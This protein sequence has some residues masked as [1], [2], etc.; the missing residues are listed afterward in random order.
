MTWLAI[1]LP[2]L[3]IG[4]GVVFVAFSGGPSAAREAYLTRGNTAFRIVVPVIY[5]LGG[6]VA[7]AVILANREAAAGA[8]PVLAGET[9]SKQVE[10]GKILFT[11]RCASCHNL[12]AANARGVQ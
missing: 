6:L 1:V 12:D 10:E 7:P 11:E 4:I 3:L 9:P 8:T 2:F 5:V